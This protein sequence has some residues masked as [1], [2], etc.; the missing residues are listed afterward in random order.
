MFSVEFGKIYRIFFISS[1]SE[2]FGNSSRINFFRV[3]SQ[4]GI[5]LRALT[6]AYAGTYLLFLCACVYILYHIYYIKHSFFLL[7]FLQF[8]RNYYN[9]VHKLSAWIWKLAAVSKTDEIIVNTVNIKVPR[10]KFLSE[11]I[12]IYGNREF[13][14]THFFSVTFFPFKIFQNEKNC[15]NFSFV[16]TKSNF[17]IQIAI[18]QRNRNWITFRTQVNKSLK[19]VKSFK[20][21]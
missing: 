5:S 18:S 2:L 17:Y 14:V 3:S 16:L 13:Q 12:E 1:V 11:K 19:P 20:K 21:I 9:G 6:S 7:L 8:V 15:I 10:K 4:P